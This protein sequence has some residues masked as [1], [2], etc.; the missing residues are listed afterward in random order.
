MKDHYMYKKIFILMSFSFSMTVLMASNHND[1]ANFICGTRVE[2][3]N[4]FQGQLS[5]SE[6]ILTLCIFTTC[7]SCNHS[8]YDEAAL[9]LSAHDAKA[10]IACPGNCLNKAKACGK[11]IADPS[12]SKMKR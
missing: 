1:N 5:T 2:N 3:N 7:Y 4:A 12:N 11:C 8:Y 10:Y 6:K 9:G